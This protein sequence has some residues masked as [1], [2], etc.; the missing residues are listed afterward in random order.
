MHQVYVSLPSAAQVQRFVKTLTPLNGDFE[1]VSDPYVLDARSLMGVFS[2]DLT[3]PVLLKIYEASDENLQ[4]V[5]PFIAPQ[6]EN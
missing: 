2:L 4:A 5:Q 3:K 6:K 1:L